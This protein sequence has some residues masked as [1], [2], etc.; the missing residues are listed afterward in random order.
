MILGLNAITQFLLALP[1]N[2]TIYRLGVVIWVMH[3][4]PPL[5]AAFDWITTPNLWCGELV[6]NGTA[7]P[8]KTDTF[9]GSSPSRTTNKRKTG[10]TMDDLEFEFYDFAE[11][12]RLAEETADNLRRMTQMQKRMRWQFG[13]PDFYQ[14]FVNAMEACQGWMSSHC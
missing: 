11:F 1:G 7:R 8:V 13:C 9:E 10:K 12:E 14:S 5:H 3:V 6:A 4:P 2:K